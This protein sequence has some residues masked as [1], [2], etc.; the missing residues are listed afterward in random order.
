MTNIS[1]KRKGKSGKTGR[2]EKRRRP[3]AKAEEAPRGKKE[4]HLTRRDDSL[5]AG[6]KENGEY[7]QEKTN[8]NARWGGTGVLRIKI[9]GSVGQGARSS[10]S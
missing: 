10:T 6:G 5:A 9:T 1:G 7:W 3:A 4:A 8:M 2:C